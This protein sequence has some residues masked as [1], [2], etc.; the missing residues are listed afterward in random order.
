MPSREQG[1]PA[2][3]TVPD[4]I[5]AAGGKLVEMLA[6]CAAAP[7]DMSIGRA[8]DDALRSLEQLIAAD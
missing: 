7:D 2:A 8:A 5:A 4:E 6:A 1:Q 3:Q